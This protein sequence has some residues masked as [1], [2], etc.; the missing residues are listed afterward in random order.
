MIENN[1]SILLCTN[2]H[3]STRPALEYGVWLAEILNKPVTLLGLNENQEF[4]SLLD[5]L[6]EKAAARLR[7]QK[8]PFTQMIEA[9]PGADTIVRVAKSGHYLTVVGPLGR[10]VWQRVVQ[11]RSFR[12]LLAKIKS[13]ILYVP[14]CCLSLEHILVCTGGLGYALS[15]ERLSLMVAR[16]AGSRIT[17]L[18]VIE[19][20]NLDYPTA[21]EIQ[22]HPDNILE[23]DTP[24]AR[25]LRQA[26][27]EIH[28]AGLTAELK[29]RHG[30]VVHEIL[31]E[32]HSGEYDLVGLG[33]PYSAK[34]LRHLYTS[35][36]TAEVAETIHV[37]VLSVR[38][39]S[40]R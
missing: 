38:F 27:T 20:I 19:P 40:E 2:G 3:Q 6:L 21:M 13:P 4:K 24:Q 25:N 9:G 33:S 22:H 16:A 14:Q 26:L 12:R 10:P 18:H 29:I 8:I 1:F 11:G 36:V 37:P 17:L 23:S 34:S 30:S 5:E 39:E 32:I 35:N 7:A 31:A 28:S 15:L